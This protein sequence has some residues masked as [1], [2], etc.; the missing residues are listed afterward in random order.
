MK[1]IFDSLDSLLAELR[2]RKVQVVRI[3]PAIYLETG[4]RTAGVPHLTSRVVVTAALDEHLWAEWRYWVGRGLAEVGDNGLHLPEALRKKA[5]VALADIS[6]QI[7]DA[8]LPL[9]D[10][11]LAPDTAAMDSFRL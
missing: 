3:S 8:G 4:P 6:K 2:D 5:N 11:M 9:R 7:D 10:G 1:L